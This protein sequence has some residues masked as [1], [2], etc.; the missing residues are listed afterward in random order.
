[1]LATLF[2]TDRLGLISDFDIEPLQNQNLFAQKDDSAHGNGEVEEAASH[3]SPQVDWYNQFIAQSSN[4]VFSDG[5]DQVQP[6]LSQGFYTDM[7]IEGT[8]DWLWN[9]LAP[10]NQS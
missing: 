8:D 4:A 10:E 5:V 6:D 2:E 7:D 3:I 9:S 1:M